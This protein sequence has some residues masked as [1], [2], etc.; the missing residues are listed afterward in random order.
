VDGG[1]GAL[2][3]AS[4]PIFNVPPVV[5]AL[6]A[7]LGIIELA[8]EWLLSQQTQ[9][10]LLAWFAFI[11][12]RYEAVAIAE[13]LYPGGLAADVWTFLSYALLHGSAMHY[14]LNAVWLLSFGTPV[15]R[16]F[17]VPRFLAFLA[18]TAAAGAAAHLVTHIGDGAPMVGA[19]AAISGCM[20]GAIRFVFQHEGPLGLL[21]RG[22]H[23]SYRVAAAPLSRALRDRRIVGFV[24]VW[25]GLNLLFGVGSVSILGEGETVAWQAHVGG[26]VAGLFGFA[27]FDPAR[28]PSPQTGEGGKPTGR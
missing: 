10:E 16:R 27:V 26:F 15:A 22:S 17:G 21:G 6:V 7:V 9:V 2:R 11:P 14:G 3:A 23:E 8:R 24:V 18:V 25:F 5:T 12:A 19:S 28:G 4:E 1:H 13:R 20:A